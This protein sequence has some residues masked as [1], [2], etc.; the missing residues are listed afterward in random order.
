MTYG[1][2]YEE[3][4][5][6]GTSDN[7]DDAVTLAVESGMR[8]D[9]VL[10]GPMVDVCPSELVDVDDVLSRAQDAM[11]DS[12]FDGEVSLA[13]NPV[14]AAAE[15]A[16]WCK[17]YLDPHP[18]TTCDGDRIPTEYAEGEWRVPADDDAAACF[19][20]YSEN[21]SP[22]TGHAGWIW[23]ALGRMGEASSYADAKAKAVAKMNEIL[24]REHKNQQAGW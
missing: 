9:K 17:K 20:T 7:Y 8:I 22:E 15:L 24:D 18:S 14:E 19:I 10:V 13:G 6:R 12:V 21:P 1:W 11:C 2:Y 3:G 16:E 23:W 5:I 4:S